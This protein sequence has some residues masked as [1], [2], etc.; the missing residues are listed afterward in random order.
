MSTMNVLAIDS[1]TE[2]LVVAAEI[3]GKYYE[4]ISDENIK[5]HNG[6]LL[7]YVDD[8]LASAGAVIGVFDVFAAVCGPGSFTGIRV[9]VATVKAFA[10]ALGKP[11]VAVDALEL[12]GYGK[13]GEFIAAIDARNDNYYAAMIKDGETVWEKSVT[14]TEMLSY[15][16]SV[17]Y[18]TLP[19]SGKDI[20]SVAE[21]RAAQ[22]LFESNLSPVYLKKS[23]AERMKDG[24]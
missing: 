21:R 23:Q 3:N 5:R 22:G 9:G 7:E 11:A 20:I 4:K 17:T 2:R 10:L 19:T 13:S 1:T 15:N 24:E 6:L 14:K 18:Q 12:I 8:I 16:V